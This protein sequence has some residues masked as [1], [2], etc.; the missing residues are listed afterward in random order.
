MFTGA[1]Y[2]MSHERI[3]AVIAAVQADYPSATEDDVISVL[4]GDWPEGR[5]HQE[6]LNNATI[7]EI[8]AWV[9]GIYVNL[10]EPARPYN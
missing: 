5:E 3:D 6:W 7:A 4:D 9:G 8:A 10:I 1:H 2:T